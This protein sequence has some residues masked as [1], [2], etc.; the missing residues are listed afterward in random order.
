MISCAEKIKFKVLNSEIVALLTEA[1]LIKL[2]QPPFNIL[3]KDDKNFLY[4]AITKDI[5]PRVLRVR[6][7]KF[8]DKAEYFGPY[9]NALKVNEVLKLL[10]KIFP[11][12]NQL[13]ISTKKSFKR[14]CFYYHL[15]LCPGVCCGQI[16]SEDYAKNILNLK[17]F[18][19]GKTTKVIQTLKQEISILASQQKYELASQFRDKLNLVIEITSVNFN[20]IN[21]FTL[22]ILSENQQQESLI[23]LKIILK[24]FFNLSANY[25]FMR[26]EAYDVSNL[27]GQQAVVS[28]VVFINGLNSPQD[29]KIFKIKTIDQA[30][31]CGMLKEALWRRW[32][33]S[34]WNYPNLIVIDGGKGQL[35]TIF[36]I[37]G[38]YFHI[39][40]IA[41]KPDRLIGVKNFYF[42]LNGR[43]H[44]SFIEIPLNNED[45]K[46]YSLKLAYRLLIDLRNKAHNFAKKNHV[47]LRNKALFD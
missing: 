25:Q 10:R 37:L 46:E 18:L 36:K 7:N 43:E 42:D 44:Y 3:L 16:K 8:K 35:K 26:I 9:P 4:I 31:D 6:K 1:E 12:C 19:Q 32:R 22:P 15:N 21:D 17:H 14:P 41:K 47:K 45:V 40:S 29:Y 27:S 33:H 39:V 30:N 38:N 34:E 24:S 11:W 13:P 28:M 23:G 2:Y 5:F 20:L